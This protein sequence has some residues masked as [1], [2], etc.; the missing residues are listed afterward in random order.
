M[1]VDTSLRL[2]FGHV[3]VSSFAATVNAGGRGGKTPL[4]MAVSGVSKQVSRFAYSSP[5]FSHTSVYMLIIM[6]TSCLRVC[7]YLL[8]LLPPGTW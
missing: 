4:H 6:F 8:A 1:V 2:V 7:V 5:M 3:I